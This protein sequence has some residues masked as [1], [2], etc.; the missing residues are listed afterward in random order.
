M[1]VFQGQKL[2]NAR[3]RRGKSIKT[4]DLKALIEQV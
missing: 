1:E 3:K 4:G 2:D